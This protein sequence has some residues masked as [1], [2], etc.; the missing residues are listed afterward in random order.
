MTTPPAPLEFPIP[1]DVEGFWSW[2]KGHFPRPATPLTQEILYGALSAGFSRAMHDWACPFGVECRA[3]NYYGFLALKPFDLGTE[4]VE[5]RGT[6]Y[7]KLLG[8][9]LPRMG[10]LW[11]QEW[12]PAILPGLERGRTAD[13]TA[14]SNAELLHT[15]DDMLRDFLARWTVH[16]YVNFVTISASWF[17]DFYNETFEPEDPTEP[18]LFLQGFPTRSL[19]AGR[20]L[21]RLSRS[22][23]TRPVLKRVFEEQEPA[24]LVAHLERSEEGRHFLGEFRAYLDEFGWRSDAFEL[25][26]PTWRE[27]PL[28]PLN[29][30]QGYISLGEEADPEAR[31][32][33]AVSTR[34]RLL[35]HAR[36]RLADDPE[37]LARFNKLYDMARHY[38]PLTEDHNFYIDQ[39]GDAV[40]RLPI[41]ELGRRLVHQGVLTGANDVFLLYLAE[42]RAGLGGANQQSVAAQRQADMAAWSRI[43]PP[44]VI[45]APPPPSDDPFEEAVL[46]KMLGMPPEPSRDPD[47]IT[48]TSASPGTVQGRAKVVHNLPEASKVHSGDILV[49][50]MTMPAWTPLFSTASAVVSDTGGILSHCAIVAREYRIPCVVGTV[51]GTSVIKDG[52]LL[53]VDGS[54]GMVRIDARV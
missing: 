13:Y 9:V 28:I 40:L 15:L 53:T 10:E 18:Y 29:T 27:S 3:I 26:D 42:I 48:G 50:D 38:L 20:G 7:Q 32:Q 46:R 54:Q 23:K 31:F 12:L 41:L 35:T 51:V 24:Q 33:A 47:V 2:E 44:P 49:C 17:A 52:M 19:D 25:A 37:K 43:I 11:E 8:E 5:D 30:L 14:L 36:Q 1:P 6:R 22:I 21:W 4:T 16:G 45:G 34:E 39:V